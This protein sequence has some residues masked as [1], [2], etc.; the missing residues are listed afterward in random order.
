MN[1]IARGAVLHPRLW[2]AAGIAV[3]LALAAGLPRLELKTDGESLQPDGN[4]VVARSDADRIRFEEPR[5][6]VL[7][8]RC[9]D[10]GCLATPK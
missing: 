4:A 3:T 7:L 1:W 6:L 10:P 8:V 9:A 5:H 2:F